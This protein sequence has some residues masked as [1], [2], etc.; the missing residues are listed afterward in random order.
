MLAI[1]CV[2]DLP[3]SFFFLK[4]IFKYKNTLRVKQDT[5]VVW[6]WIV[7]SNFHLGYWVVRDSLL[8]RTVSPTFVKWTHLCVYEKKSTNSDTENR[9]ERSGCRRMR[10]KVVKYMVS[11]GN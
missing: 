1:K 7:S 4:L 3:L 11:K 9:G 6:I 5:S 10:V 8:P 2:K